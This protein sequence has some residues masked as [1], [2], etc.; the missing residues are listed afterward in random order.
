MADSED[1]TPAERKKDLEADATVAQAGNAGDKR[2]LADVEAEVEARVWQAQTG[3]AA[4]PPNPMPNQPEPTPEAAKEK[5][6][7]SQAE[8]MSDRQRK[9]QEQR[10][11][12]A[13][14]V[15]EAGEREIEEWKKAN[16]DKVKEAEERQAER[17][18]TQTAR[19]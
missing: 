12:E 3:G 5:Y 18:Q 4:F 14:Q 16:P 7:E 9:A 6:L 10:D 11:K 2:A 19:R 15:R 13:Q 8:H 17:Q 1:R